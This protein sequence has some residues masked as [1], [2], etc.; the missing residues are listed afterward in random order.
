MPHSDVATVP[1][2]LHHANFFRL[3]TTMPGD[4]TLQLRFAFLP[5][6]NFLLKVDAFDPLIARSEPVAW[7]KSHDNIAWSFP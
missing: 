4:E 5:R 1:S 7:A 3:S 2:F 6:I